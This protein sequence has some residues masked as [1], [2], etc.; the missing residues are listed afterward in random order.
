MVS[1][2][3]ML[4][5]TVLKCKSC[6][7]LHNVSNL[8]PSDTNPMPL[9]HKCVCVCVSFA[10]SVMQLYGHGLVAAASSLIFV[11]TTTKKTMVLSRVSELPVRP[12]AFVFAISQR[13]MAGVQ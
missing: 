3:E 8:F 7:T 2:T 13:C 10:C 1:V 5:L 11:I 4:V 12:Q 6:F 9:P